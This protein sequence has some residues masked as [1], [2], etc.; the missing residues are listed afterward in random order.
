MTSGQPKRTATTAAAGVDG[1]GGKC[2][3]ATGNSHL[4]EPQAARHQRRSGPAARPMT[5]ERI[6][7]RPYRSADTDLIGQ[8]AGRL[9][10][11]ALYERF[12]TGMPTLPPQYYAALARVDHHDREALLALDGEAA[13]GITEYVRDPRTPARADLAIIVADS[14]Q[15]R[16][17]AQ[18]L[19][20][21]L[22]ALAASRGITDFTADVLA[23][24]RHA[25][26]AIAT[27][28]PHAKPRLDGTTAHFTLPVAA[29][30]RRRDD[31][32]EAT[33]ALSLPPHRGPHTALH[34]TPARP[35]ST[36]GDSPR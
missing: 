27:T 29:L 18:A 19:V 31:T 32:A 6:R 23:S 9:S 34:Q 16:G 2:R 12:F 25:L 17:V 10:S 3:A 14:W 24:N 35:G 30:A 22:A 4:P 11:R 20:T 21:E 33:P 28:W 7:I 8:L 26:A 1:P 5:A 13:V 36:A 15:R